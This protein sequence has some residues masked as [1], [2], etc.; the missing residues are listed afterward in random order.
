ML[1]SRKLMNIRIKKRLNN[2]ESMWSNVIDIIIYVQDINLFAIP[3]EQEQFLGWEKNE[4][5]INSIVDNFLYDL[6]AQCWKELWW[7]FFMHSIEYAL[8]NS[9]LYLF[10][11]WA[12]LCGHVFKIH[13]RMYCDFFCSNPTAVRAIVN[14]F[15]FFLV[16]LLFATVAFRMFVF[17]RIFWFCRVNEYRLDI[18]EMLDT[19][20]SFNI[21]TR[22]A[23]H[24]YAFICTNK[25]Q[26]QN[27]SAK[28]HIFIYLILLSCC[29]IIHWFI[30]EWAL[31]LLMR[32]RKLL[33]LNANK[34]RS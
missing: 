23:L 24:A 7:K 3:L 4:F 20:Y 19:I 32:K 18:I 8:T 29:G 1:W 26:N 22:I 15:C 13:S 12:R 2:S 28:A 6:Y 10:N 11:E 33:E 27:V 21:S 16:S 5:E 30:H 17:P 9:P 34:M 14:R 31:M 25:H